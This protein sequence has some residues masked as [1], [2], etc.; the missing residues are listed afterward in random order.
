VR[1]ELR[2]SLRAL[3]VPTLAFVLVAVLLPGRLGVAVR[4]YAL[5]LAGIGLL[6]ALAMLRRSYPPATPLAVAPP[7]P[8]AATPPPALARL[9]HLSAL[10]VAGSFDLHH[11]L[12]PRLRAIGAG[13][14]ETRRRI[15]LDGQPDAARQALGAETYELLR[16]DRPRPQDRLARGLEIAELRRVVERLEDV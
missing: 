9:A 11:R 1:R 12:R 6:V 8:R 15:S 16:A 3:V 2:A 13:V 5:L 4:L 7:Q 14:L 10:G